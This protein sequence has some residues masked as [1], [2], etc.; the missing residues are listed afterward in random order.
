MWY[1]TIL[2]RNTLET[3]SSEWIFR[4]DTLNINIKDVL[5][6][7]NLLG[8]MSFLTLCSFS[9]FLHK[10]GNSEHERP[11]P[12]QHQ[13]LLGLHSVELVCISS[14]VTRS[15]IRSLILN[16]ELNGWKCYLDTNP[17]LPHTPPSF[18]LEI[19][20]LLGNTHI[21]YF[22]GC[23]IYNLYNIYIIFYINL[24][25]M[26]LYFKMLNKFIIIFINVNLYL[27]NV[28]YKIYIKKFI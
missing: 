15:S 3:D 20:D 25:F 7:T 19:Y 4:W 5:V 22:T 2:W 9:P 18:K 10:G 27:Y 11:N 21:I 16:C 13:K 23:I 17:H 24:C 28:L 14:C 12:S 1:C 8:K 6:V 26:N